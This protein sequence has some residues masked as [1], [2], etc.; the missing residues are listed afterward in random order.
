MSKKLDSILSRVPSATASSAIRGKQHSVNTEQATEESKVERM[1]RL[2]AVIPASVKK[3][4]RV[5]LANNPK[6]NERT[7]VLKG[8]KALGFNIKDS[9]LIDKRGYRT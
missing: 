2:V 6:E 8:L 5:Y 7:I 3:E 4:I 1:E 9:E